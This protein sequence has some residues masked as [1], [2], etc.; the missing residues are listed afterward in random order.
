MSKLQRILIIA[1]VAQLALI[2]FVFW[3]RPAASAGEPLLGALTTGDVTAITI[4]DDQ[5]V[6]TRLVKQGE[7]WVAASAA[8]YPADAAKITPVI[9]QLVAIKAGKAVAT[10]AASHA[11][12]QVADNA[13][14]RKIELT[15]V[16]GSTQTIYVGSQAGGQS[17]YTR[18]GGANEVYLS[19]GL[20]AREVAADVLSWINPV[21]LSVNARDVTGLTLK[22]PNGE[23][24]LTQDAQGQWQL[25]GLETGE[26]LDTNKAAS[27]VS[28]A[29]SFRMTQPLGKTEDS[30]WG[31]QQPTAIAAL[32]VKSGEAIQTITLTIGAQ[33]ASD[34]SYVVKSSESEYYVRVADYAVEELVSRDRAGFL[35]AT[36]TPAAVATP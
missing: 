22:N 13:F 9:D 36:P 34:N 29:S 1:L 16:D 11:Q 21:Y 28:A 20:S 18:L 7:S 19:N 26:T 4:T 5:G 6:S 17:A 10:T 27:L 24:A 33:D 12:L 35:T 23:F 32:Q 31:L 25:F 2:A 15:K 3:P 14:Q 30:A 8:D